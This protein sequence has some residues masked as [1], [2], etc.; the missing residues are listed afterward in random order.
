MKRHP[1]TLVMVGVVVATGVGVGIGGCGH[2]GAKREEGGAER[3]LLFLRRL[4]A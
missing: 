3:R 1:A 4:R 2:D